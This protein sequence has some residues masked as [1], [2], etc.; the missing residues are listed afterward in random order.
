M[1]I[2]QIKKQLKMKNFKISWCENFLTFF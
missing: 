2:L 1:E